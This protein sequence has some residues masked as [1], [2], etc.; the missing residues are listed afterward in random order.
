MPC[1]AARGRCDSTQQQADTDERG[2]TDEQPGRSL[3]RLVH[4]WEAVH[5]AHDDKHRGPR[6][7]RDEQPDDELGHRE[8]PAWEVGCCKSPED[9]PLTVSGE[10]HGQHHEPNRRDD[11]GEIARRVPMRRVHWEPVVVRVERSDQHEHGDHRKGEHKGQHQWFAEEEPQL[12]A[13]ELRNGG[14]RTPPTSSDSP[15][16]NATIAS[17]R[18]GHLDAQV[19]R[20]RVGA[21]RARRP[22][23]PPSR[24][25]RAEPDATSSTCT[26]CTPGTRS[27]TGAS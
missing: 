8:G 6:G 9:S 21:A 12:H 19:V 10:V 23:G 24:G 22:R 27:S 2:S 4:V 25:R 20:H 13:H 18:F 11:H 3:Q 16:S 15:R 26:S 17:S 7:D 14:H 1:G 5:D